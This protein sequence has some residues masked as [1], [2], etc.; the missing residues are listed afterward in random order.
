[1]FILYQ[2]SRYSVIHALTYSSYTASQYARFMI[3][4]YL[5]VFHIFS[6]IYIFLLD[7]ICLCSLYSRPI[8]LLPVQCTFSIFHLNLYSKVQP[9]LTCIALILYKYTLGHIIHNQNVH[10]LYIYILSYLLYHIN[11]SVHI[12]YVLGTQCTLYYF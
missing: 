3:I 9:Y 6:Y 4:Y 11:I 10:S 12:I 2:T 7:C 1:M 8:I 5:S